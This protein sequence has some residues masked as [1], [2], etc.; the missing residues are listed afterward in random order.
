MNEREVGGVV[1]VLFRDQIG[2]RIGR[3]RAPVPERLTLSRGKP[4][5]R[6]IE[7]APLFLLPFQIR[8]RNYQRGHNM[9]APIKISSDANESFSGPAKLDKRLLFALRF[10]RHSARVTARAPPESCIIRPLDGINGPSANL[11]LVG[12]SSGTESNVNIDFFSFRIW[13]GRKGGKSGLLKSESWK[14][15]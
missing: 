13:G 4:M 6:P 5:F 14:L 10:M 3:K 12:R 7:T 11:S 15:G 1:F 2:K 8:P 9:S